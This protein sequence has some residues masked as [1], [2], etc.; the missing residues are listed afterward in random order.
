MIRESAINILYNKKYINNNQCKNVY[1]MVA[2]YNGVVLPNYRRT[3]GR[4][5]C[6]GK[7]C[8]KW[9]YFPSEKSKGIIEKSK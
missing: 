2:I 9:C 1:I 8:Y 3:W 5:F 7:A 4:W 6:L